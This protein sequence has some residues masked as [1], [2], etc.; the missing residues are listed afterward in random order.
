MLTITPLLNF[1]LVTEGD[2]LNEMID[3]VLRQNQIE[4]LD[5]DILVVTQKIVSK[6]EGRYISLK[7]IV[8]SSEAENLAFSTEKDPR[9]VQLILDE[10]NE[11]VRTRPGVIITEHRLGFVCANAGVDR[12]NLPVSQED[13]MALC[14]PEH[15][16]KSAERLRLF[17]TNKY[18]KAIGILIIDSHGRAW[19]QGTVGISIGTSGVPMLINKIGETDM[20]GR[21]LKATVIAAAD[22]LAATAALVMGE[23]DEGTPVVH[24]RGFPYPLQFESSIDD[25][26]RPKSKDLFR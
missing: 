9:L 5:N 17:L 8:P 26:L 25:V 1:P 13:E 21:T 6:S 7:S 16:D 22:Q 24:V 3:G 19:R 12:S 14:L 18:H 10:S 4:L 23:A 20:F 2:D 15:P 11:V